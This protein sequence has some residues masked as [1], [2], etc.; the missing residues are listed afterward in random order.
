MD[1]IVKLELD[2]SREPPPR[3][4]RAD[5]LGV[6]GN[7]G[8]ETR[9]QAPV[10]VCVRYSDVPAPDFLGTFGPKLGTSPKVLAQPDQ[11]T[12]EGQ[13]GLSTTL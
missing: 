7:R 2:Y 12:G 5:G 13:S 10:A 11:P 9:V 6:G 3:F 4:G 8:A 1:A